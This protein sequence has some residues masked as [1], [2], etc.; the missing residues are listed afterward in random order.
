MIN[1][2][3]APIIMSGLNFKICKKI[4][5]TNFF[6]TFVWG[7]N[8]CGWSSNYVVGVILLQFHYFISLET[9]KTHKSEVFLL[10][11]SSGNVNASEVVTCR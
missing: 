6:P 11:I 5:G 9:A 1:M 8:L 4:L 2:V 3:S 7:I 10:R